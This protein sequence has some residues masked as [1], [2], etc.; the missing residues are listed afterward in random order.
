MWKQLKETTGKDY[1]QDWIAGEE[2]DRELPRPWTKLTNKEINELTRWAYISYH[3]RPTFIFKHL[4]NLHSFS[5]FKR[6]LFAFF[7]MLFNQEKNAKKDEQF[8][9]FNNIREKYI[10]QFRKRIT[11]GTR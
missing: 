5:E 8:K 4:L 3:L 6:K 1:W 2:T 11:E 7:D 9:V 10:K